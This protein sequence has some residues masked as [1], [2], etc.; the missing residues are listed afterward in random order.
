M[1][2]L[3]NSHAIRS[4]LDKELI[5][6]TSLRWAV[7]WASKQ[8]PSAE[9]LISMSEKVEQLTVGVHFYQTDPDFI[10]AFL[11]HPNAQFVMNPDGVFHPK[12]YLFEHADVGWSC[13]TGSPNFTR[14]ALESN[15]ETAVLITDDDEGAAAALAAICETLDG[16]RNLGS[17][18]D[19]SDLEAYR[20]LWRRQQRR[21]GSLSGRYDNHEDRGQQRTR[22]PSPLDVPL[23]RENW[24]E[25][26]QA[27]REHEQHTT[28]GR[29]AVLERA[30]ELFG[31]HQHFADMSEDERRG[32]AGLFNAED[33]EWLWFGSMRG[34]GSFQTAIK[35]NNSEISRALDAIPHTGEVSEQ[36]YREFAE[37]FSAGFERSGLA[38][39]SRLLA[40]K[41]P[42]YFVCLD[43]KNKRKL[44][45][46][47][48][49]TRQVDFDNYWDKVVARLTDA[50]WWNAP[51][52]KSKL[53]R[54]VWKCRAAFLDA[55]FYEPEG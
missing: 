31:G 21:L 49:I 40:M 48:G 8:A 16:Y 29:L 55:R 38:V 10:E 54:R 43:S 32:I 7:A 34:A 24:A 50:N 33:V 27:L 53:E 6:C 47:F 51:A 37:I 52:P 4:A 28:E 26:F 42:D 39:G 2:V 35:S 12:L 19:G 46:D 36:H 11:D 22:V 9:L 13:I 14:G 3:Q 17:A 5:R 30:N 1:R 44:C 18:V 41:R 45:E 25:F 23:F 20:T 15:A